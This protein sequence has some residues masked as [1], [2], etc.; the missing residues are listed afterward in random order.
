MT[1]AEIVARIEQLEAQLRQ[2]DKER[3]NEKVS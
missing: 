3:A 2:L 1:A